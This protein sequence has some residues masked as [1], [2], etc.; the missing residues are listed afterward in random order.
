MPSQLNFKA[1][2]KLGVVVHSFNL[3]TWEAEAV[4]STQV[5]G[6]LR[7]CGEFKASLDY[8][9]RFYLKKKKISPKE[10][11]VNLAVRM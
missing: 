11:L 5:L 10:L 4:L 9:V 1:S 8:I 3:S 7:V 6:Q 2:P